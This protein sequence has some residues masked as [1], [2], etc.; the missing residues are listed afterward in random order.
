MPTTPRCKGTLREASQRLSDRELLHQEVMIPV[1]ERGADGR[2]LRARPG[3]PTP[4]PAGDGA[5]RDRLRGFQHRLQLMANAPHLPGSAKRRP[6][7]AWAISCGARRCSIRA[8][9]PI[10]T[11]LRALSSRHGAG[12]YAGPFGLPALAGAPADR[13]ESGRAR[14]SRACAEIRGIAAR[15]GDRELRTAR[16]ASAHHSLRAVFPISSTS[17]SSARLAFHSQPLAP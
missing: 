14:R 4:A 1:L 8:R 2:L 17:G 7:P 16:A 9:D 11:A 12:G 6:R 10:W 5:Q 3:R 15:A 13:Q